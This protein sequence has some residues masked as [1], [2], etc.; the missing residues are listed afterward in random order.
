MQ[1]AIENICKFY[2]EGR[3]VGMLVEVILFAAYV[4]QSPFC[5]HL[6][7]QDCWWKQ[8]PQIQAFPLFLTE[9]ETCMKYYERWAETEA[10]SP[11]PVTRKSIRRAICTW[12][13]EVEAARCIS[14]RCMRGSRTFVVLGVAH[15]VA[16]R[17][18][19]AHPW[20]PGQVCWVRVLSS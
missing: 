20:D 17:Q 7:R 18:H 1:R 9:C 4:D 5:L 15:D 13:D 12:L 2:L 10:S 8:P 6:L 16:S 11:C 19:A 14:S 3:E